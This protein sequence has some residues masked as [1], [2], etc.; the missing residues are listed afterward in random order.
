[1]GSA[2]LPP[3]LEGHLRRESVIV[4]FLW[5]LSRDGGDGTWA[6]CRKLARE[7]GQMMFLVIQRML[8]LGL[9]FWVKTTQKHV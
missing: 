7:P 4:M 3:V 6:T 1:M 8:A 9:S 2:Q 5:A